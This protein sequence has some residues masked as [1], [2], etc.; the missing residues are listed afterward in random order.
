MTKSEFIWMKI[1]IQLNILR[2]YYILTC[3]SDFIITIL[4]ISQALGNLY[5]SLKTVDDLKIWNFLTHEWN[6]VNDKN[7]HTG[8]IES[9]ATKEKAKFPQKFFPE[10]THELISI[11]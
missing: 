1:T 2:L 4:C 9:I 5:F 6:I 7:I 10:V 3:D 8:N 11:I